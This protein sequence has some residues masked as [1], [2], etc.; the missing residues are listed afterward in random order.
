M[1][2]GESVPAWFRRCFWHVSHAG[3]AKVLAL[4]DSG[5]A[6]RWSAAIS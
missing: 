1:D 4:S 3:T 5:V 2:S 6:Q